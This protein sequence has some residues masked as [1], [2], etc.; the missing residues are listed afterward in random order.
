MALEDYAQYAPI[1]QCGRQ[2]TATS[3]G[4][5]YITAEFNGFQRVNAATGGPLY[6]YVVNFSPNGVGTDVHGAGGVQSEYP[7]H[8]PAPGYPLKI[9][10][11]YQGILYDQRQW[12]MQAGRGPGLLCTSGFTVPN[13]PSNFSGASCLTG[14]TISGTVPAVEGLAAGANISVQSGP[15]V[16]DNKNGTVLY[17]RLDAFLRDKARTTGTLWLDPAMPPVPVQVARIGLYLHTLQDT[18]SHSTFCGD[19]A[20]S[21]PGGSDVG[22]YMA[23]G[24]GGVQLV[25]GTYC[26]IGPHIASHVQE[27]GTGEQPLPLRDYVALNM[28]VDELIVFGNGV[29]KANGWIVNPQL[30]PPN[31][32]GGR[33]AAGASA[34][35]LRARLVGTIV[36]G[37]RWTRAEAYRSAAVT[38]PLQQ[39]IS[40]DRLHAMNAALAAYSDELRARSPAGQRF[41]PFQQMPGNS[42]S[43][44]DTSVCFK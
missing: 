31:V 3:S 27:T 10:D 37:Q 12:A 38:R 35:D 19:D 25:F 42:A 44:G 4:K 13:G 14:V 15:K 23:M 16:L 2:A 1:D 20:P 40:L 43:P 32:T 18:A 8:Y 6:H 36:S 26:A 30:L 11:V 34:E 22:S 5:S 7:F 29:A 28:T 33:S 17:E 41:T 9:D 39:P 24:S 21:P